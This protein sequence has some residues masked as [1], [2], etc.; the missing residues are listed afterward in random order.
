MTGLA[1]GLVLV[2]DDSPVI[3]DLIAVN[4]E[5]EGFD[6]AVAGD[7]EEALAMVARRSDMCFLLYTT[8]CGKAV[9]GQVGTIL[10]CGGDGG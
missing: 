5:L 6:V 7:G 9:D 8:M 4:L 10:R 3:R 1:T 2:V